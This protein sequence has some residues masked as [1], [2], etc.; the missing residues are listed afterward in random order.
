MGFKEPFSGVFERSPPPG[1][2]G[3]IVHGIVVELEKRQLS[4]RS[5]AVGGIG[6]RQG[7]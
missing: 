3:S 6:G 7:R 4:Q 2:T 1:I 5:G